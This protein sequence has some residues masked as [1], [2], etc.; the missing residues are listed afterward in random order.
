[1]DNLPTNKQEYN[2]E[3]LSHDLL[4]TMSVIYANM[5]LLEIYL[6]KLGLEKE[7]TIAKTVI[8]EVKK[9]NFLIS[10][11]MNLATEETPKKSGGA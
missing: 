7:V 10:E 9:M 2:L 8:H 11:G 1:M 5:Q 6:T 3:R 4:N